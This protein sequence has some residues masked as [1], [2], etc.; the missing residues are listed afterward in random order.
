MQRQVHLVGLILGKEV[1]D[2]EKM[3]MCGIGFC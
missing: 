2:N 1:N 3:D